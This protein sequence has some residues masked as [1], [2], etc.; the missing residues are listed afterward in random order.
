MASA[1]D[2]TDDVFDQF[3]TQRGHETEHVTW[4]DDYNKKRCPECGGLHEPDAS[5]CGVCG[6]AP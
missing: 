4:E 3:L 1:P 5:E 6:W 2:D